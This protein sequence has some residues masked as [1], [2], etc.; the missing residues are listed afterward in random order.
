MEKK[1]LFSLSRFF[2][3]EL[4]MY[5]ATEAARKKLNG[6][7]SSLSGPRENHIPMIL[8]GQSFSMIVIYCFL[9]TNPNPRVGIGFLY[10]EQA[11]SAG[12]F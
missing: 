4:S 9:Q 5:N 11:H 6:I 1:Y 3:C 12:N 7:D 10:K 2:A 8:P